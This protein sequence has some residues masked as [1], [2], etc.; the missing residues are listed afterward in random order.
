MI[1]QQDKIKLRFP[2]D[3]RGKITT[4]LKGSKDKKGVKK[5]LDYFSIEEFEELTAVYGNKPTKLLLYFPPGPIEDY[6]QFYYAEWGQNN[7]AKRRCNR[8]IFTVTFDHD[9]L[10]KGENYSC[11]YPECKCKPQVYFNAFIGNPQN[12]R[13]ISNF[14]KTYLF[15]TGSHENGQ[16]IYTALKMKEGMIFGQ[17]YILS[18]N[19]ITDGDK[20]YPSWNIEPRHHLNKQLES[21][22]IGGLLETDNIPI[23]LQL[24]EGKDPDT[25]EYHLQQQTEEEYDKEETLLKE[26]DEILMTIN[27][28][29]EYE[30]AKKKIGEIYKKLGSEG[31]AKITKWMNNRKKAIDE[32]IK[33]QILGEK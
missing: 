8:E 21:H 31:Q 27:N 9:G 29:E 6:F 4:G 32:D 3:D 17:A 26:A 13:L 7:K 20:A 24:T 33:N 11:Q 2:V 22:T 23:D 30:I 5:S 28:I 25:T 15:R 1:I 19:W 18:V 10:K 12:G 16:R 14:G